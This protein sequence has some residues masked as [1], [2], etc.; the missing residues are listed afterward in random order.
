MGLF[1][2]LGQTATINY[3][4]GG[5][6]KVYKT[7]NC[8]VDVTLE[9]TPGCTSIEVTYEYEAAGYYYPNYHVLSWLTLSRTITLQ[10]PITGHRLLNTFNGEPGGFEIQ[11]FCAG[12]NTC[13]PPASWRTSYGVTPSYEVRNLRIISS[14]KL[15]N[16]GSAVANYSEEKTSLIVKYNNQII[17]TD[18]APGEG[19]FTVKC[20]DDCPPGHIKC[21]HARYPGYCCLPCK[22]T[23]EKISNLANKIR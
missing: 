20:D 13:D 17:F 16:N 15:D 22:P 10:S 7:E 4:L 18:T 14:K 21:E 9:N 5:K 2:K 19:S 1:C 12:Y 23:A 11:H 6:K 8:P 3:I